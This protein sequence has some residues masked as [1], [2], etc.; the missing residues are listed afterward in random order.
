MVVVILFVYTLCLYWFFHVASCTGSM[1]HRSVKHFGYEFL[2]GSNSI[3][4]NKPLKEKIPSICDDLINR[5]KR[6][7]IIDFI[8][9]Q[10]TIN[11][12]EPGQGEIGKSCLQMLYSPAN[13]Y[14]FKV[15]IA[16]L[17]KGVKYVQSK[18]QNTPERRHWRRSFVFIVYFGH[19]SHLFLVFQ[20]LTLN[21]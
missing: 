3:D 8:P 4:K 19:M 1:K 10:L 14:L 2:Y 7:S 16:I 12:Y 5:M 17:E 21:K 20:L 11:Q 6:Q 13:T 18:Q 9:D 15:V